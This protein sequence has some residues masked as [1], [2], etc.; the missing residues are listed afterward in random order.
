M[1]SPGQAYLPSPSGGQN[2]WITLLNWANLRRACASNATQNA[3]AR[4]VCR[5]PAMA[6]RAIRLR[7][8][9]G[10]TVATLSERPELLERLPFGPGWPKFIFHDAVASRLMPAVDQL[11][12]DFSLVLLDHDDQV[13]AGGWGV[14]ISWDHTVEGLP[15]GWDGALERAVSGNDEGDAPNALCAMATEV[16]EGHRGEG[17]SSEILRALRQRA[18][19]SGLTQMVAPAR[20]TLKHR[21]PL[22]PIE[23]YARWR[24]EDGGPFDPWLHVHWRVGAQVFAPEPHAMEILGTISEW[25]EWLGMALPESGKYVVP[26]AL[27]P[28]MVDRDADR[29]LYIEPAVWMLHD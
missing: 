22:I 12:S 2:N 7:P 24:Q 16:V 4:S 17:L 20:P 9:G 13:L 6:D 8:M 11:F 27:A 1:T 23:R 29:V 21:Y 25:E 28:I 26:E 19:T 14:P 10:A 15:Q 3:E 18:T 5:K